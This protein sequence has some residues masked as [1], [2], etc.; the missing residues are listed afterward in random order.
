MD[1]VLRG[2]ADR[3]APRILVGGPA[4][5]RVVLAANPAARARGVRPGQ[6]LAQ[7][8]ALA[9][10]LAESGC[11]PGQLAAWQRLLAAWAYRFSSQVSLH[12]GNALL[13]EVAGSRRLFG[14]WPHFQARL[15]AGL[16]ELGFRH[17][18]VA[19]PNPFAARVLANV[20]DGLA[21]DEDG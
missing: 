17:R 16:E 14:D 21:V 15:R 13:L 7:A 9:H 8:R 10:G 12:G 6:P 1:G 20:H 18:I 3:Q 11:D 19:A 5:R 4:Q 2:C